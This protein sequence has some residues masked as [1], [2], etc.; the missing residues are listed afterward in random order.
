MVL[1]AGD[2]EAP[3][4]WLVGPAERL[5]DRVGEPGADVP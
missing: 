4:I 2:R 3:E 1:S 5:H